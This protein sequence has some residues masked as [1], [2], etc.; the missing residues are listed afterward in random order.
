[1]SETT[2]RIVLSCTVI[3]FISCVCLSLLLIGWAGIII[4]N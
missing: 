4:F 3:L 1:M 2:R